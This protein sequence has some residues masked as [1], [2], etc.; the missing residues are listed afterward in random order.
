MKTNEAKKVSKVMAEMSAQ[1]VNPVMVAVAPIVNK[2]TEEAPKAE[3]MA[4]VADAE[5]VEEAPKA[6]AKGKKKPTK[7]QTAEELQAEIER[8][9]AELQRCLADLERKKKLSSDRSAFMAALDDLDV[10][11]KRLGDED[12]F[13]SP[14]YKLRFSQGYGSSSDVFALSNRFVLLEFIGF[15][16]GRIKSKISEIEQM[17][18]SE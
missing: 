18:I 5:K 2:P 8:K 4:V 7:K 12:S 9:T 14:H 10:A 1:S 3:E 15:M 6:E 17:L 11:E 13:D 16:R